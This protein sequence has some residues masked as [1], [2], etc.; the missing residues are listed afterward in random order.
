VRKGNCAAIFQHIAASEHKI[1][2]QAFKVL[3]LKYHP[4]KNPDPNAQEMF[5]RIQLAKE[6][7]LD[8][9]TKAALLRVKWYVADTLARCDGLVLLLACSVLGLVALSF[10]PCV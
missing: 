7:L 9:E 2:V 1:T 10:G 8:P 6:M 3:A 4:D 5:Q